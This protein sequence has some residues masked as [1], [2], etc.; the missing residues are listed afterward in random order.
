MTNKNEMT[1]YWYAGDV[2]A[3]MLAVKNKNISLLWELNS[4]FI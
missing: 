4:I 3:T 2:T 1:N